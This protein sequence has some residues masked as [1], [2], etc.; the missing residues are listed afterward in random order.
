MKRLTIPSL[1]L[2]FPLIAA[3]ATA[4]NTDVTVL[5]DRAV[6]KVH[7]NPDFAKAVLLEADGSPAGKGA[8]TRT[9]QI[10]RWRPRPK[11]SA[12]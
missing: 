3:T 2:A 9:S 5:F 10:T 11:R 8:V 12:R 1:L 4:A 7:K 6:A